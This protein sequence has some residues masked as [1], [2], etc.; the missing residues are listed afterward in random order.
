MV[1]NSICASLSKGA[2]TNA[3]DYNLN[4]RFI[5]VRKAADTAAKRFKI[6]GRY[7]DNTEGSVIPGR[8][9]DN[10][11]REIL[12][13]QDADVN[14]L[15]S[16]YANKMYDDSTIQ[17]KKFIPGRFGDSKANLY[18]RYALVNTE[19]KRIPGRY[20]DATY[21]VIPGRYGDTASYDKVDDVIRGRYRDEVKS[22]EKGS[23]NRYKYRTERF[24]NDGRKD[25][26]MRKRRNLQPL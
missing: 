9:G 21:K 14:A 17:R 11:L 12:L 4:G 15:F 3:K 20:G 1:A 26:N 5:N 6:P 7:G 24:G 13:R 19:L 22:I 25:E 8:Y 18:R 2:D 23:D 10:A 16:G